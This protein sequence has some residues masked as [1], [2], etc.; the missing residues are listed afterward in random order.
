[1]TGNGKGEP[2][3]I[4]G[5]EARTLPKR[6]YSTVA[7]E[8]RA[9]GFGI[10]LD[11]RLARTPKKNALVVP[12]L[13]LAEAVA[14]EWQ[15]Q[16]VHIDPATMPLT[17]LANTTLDG[18]TGR[19]ADVAADIAKYA[20]T[21]LLYYRAAHPPGLARRQAEL[22]DPVLAWATEMLGVNFRVATG[23][24]PIEQAP[25]VTASVLAR[26]E[27]QPPVVLTALHVITTLTGSA[28]LALAVLDRRLTPQE[29]WAA[30]HVDEDWQIAEWG[31]DAE[32]QARRAQRWRD[33]EA[34][35]RWL[36]LLG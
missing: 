16:T 24:M 13:R 7:V 26:V 23:L 4:P 10:A 17:R 31:E 30:A 28:L 11:G 33:M 35:G 20:G 21:D 8:E 15:Q 3:R 9:D 22:W 1:M 36:D 29:A 34:A 32:A 19:E 12:T 25:G 6:F 27:V 5:R 14:D 18:V 2:I